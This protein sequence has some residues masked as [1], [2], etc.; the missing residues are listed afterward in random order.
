MNEFNKDNKNE[1]N[2]PINEFKPLK[3]V[4]YYPSKEVAKAPLEALTIK[5]ENEASQAKSVRQVKI[6][7][8]NELDDLRNKYRNLNSDGTHA[9]EPTG[10]EESVGVSTGSTTA[11]STTGSTATTTA[12]STSAAS[13]TSSVVA[14]SA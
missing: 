9:T 2:N 5:E 10:V 3:A 14:T 7:D 12:A 8:K 13:A 6:K 4:E 11:A 1:Y